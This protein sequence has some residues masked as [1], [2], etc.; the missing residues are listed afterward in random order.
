VGGLDLPD[1]DFNYDKFVEEE[2]GAEKPIPRGIEWYWWVVAALLAAGM[3]FLLL[4]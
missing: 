1:P 3:T 4:R 2:F